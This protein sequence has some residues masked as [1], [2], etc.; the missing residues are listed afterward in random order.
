MD[1]HTIPRLGGSL[2]MQ[3]SEGASGEER[4][5]R[6]KRIIT[7]AR[8]EQNRAAQKA[9]R[10]RIKEA[11]QNA[12]T[13]HVKGPHHLSEL[14]PRYPPP[15]SSTQDGGPVSAL[16]LNTETIA[17]VNLGPTSGLAAARPSKASKPASSTGELKLSVSALHSVEQSR[18]SV[19]SGV[20]PEV[21][22]GPHTLSTV[23][24]ESRAGQ[25]QCP[26]DA[27]LAPA[28][29]LANTIQFSPVQTVTA[30]LNNARRLRLNL[31][32]L[33]TSDYISPFY[34]NSLPSQQ[35]QPQANA[36][37]RSL[38]LQQPQQQTSHHW[39]PP[40]L[41]PTLAQVLYPHH[42]FLD[43]LPFPLLR[44]R[45]IVMATFTPRHVFDLA[46]FK[47]DIVTHGGLV[48]WATNARGQPWD[49]RNWEATPWF[50]D[51][52]RVLVD[53]GDDG[54]GIWSQSSWWWTMRAV[55]DRVGT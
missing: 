39:I 44:A 21:H 12:I 47:N 30:A 29:P 4:G 17:T 45:A 32:R 13:N 37:P 52:W 40:D 23:L 55:S 27:R 43:L 50:L 6:R 33:L 25:M 26:P 34:Q 48:C 49:R 10:H 3:P 46:D 18:S 9:Y 16:N 20:L 42:P 1:N 53:D 28:D 7:A 41:Q 51:K 5:S 2:T 8:R 24:S 19:S 54:A 11:R 38:L 31:S 36:D 14:R 15:D 35:Q 22:P